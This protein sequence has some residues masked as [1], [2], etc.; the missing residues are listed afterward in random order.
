MN[1]LNEKKATTINKDG[2]RQ[3]FFSQDVKNPRKKMRKKKS[4]TRLSA[5][6][7]QALFLQSDDFRWKDKS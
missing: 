1:K 6:V 3:N 4:N 2:R 7:A 5:S